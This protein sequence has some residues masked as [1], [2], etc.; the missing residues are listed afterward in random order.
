MVP[1]RILLFELDVRYLLWLSWYQPVAQSWVPEPVGDGDATL[2]QSDRQ[3]LIVVR[4][5]RAA[6]VDAAIR[7]LGLLQSD[8]QQ[9]VGFRMVVPR[10]AVTAG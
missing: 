10:H 8:R 6:V 4:I 9:P 7:C 5:R 3:V 1:L 2:S